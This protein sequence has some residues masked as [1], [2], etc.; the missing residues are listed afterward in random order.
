MCSHK[1]G[2][3]KSE[4]TAKGIKKNYHKDVKHEPLKKVSFNNKRLHR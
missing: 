4:R 1:K 3:D 2:I